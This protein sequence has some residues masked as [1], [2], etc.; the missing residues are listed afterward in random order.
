MFHLAYKSV[1]VSKSLIYCTQ[2]PFKTVDAGLPEESL[3]E[4][5]AFM[6]VLI[7]RGNDIHL[8]INICVWRMTSAS[9]SVQQHTQFVL[10]AAREKRDME[11]RHAA[12]KKKV[13]FFTKMNT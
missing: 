12:V 6:R 1:N 7:K 11:Q 5:N 9:V 10:N 4:R 8:K 3:S 13:C 2:E